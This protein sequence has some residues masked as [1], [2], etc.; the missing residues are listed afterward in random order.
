MLAPLC[1]RVQLLLFVRQGADTEEQDEAGSKK[2]H[3]FHILPRSSFSS[4]ER[5]GQAL[6]NSAGL[7]YLPNKLGVIRKMTVLTRDE[8]FFK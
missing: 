5:G 2:D 1:A 6:V 4:A 7:G 3:L 8:I